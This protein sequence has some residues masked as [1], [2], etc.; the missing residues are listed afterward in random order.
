MIF[1]FKFKIT[2]ISSK[3][4]IWCTEIIIFLVIAKEKRKRK[5]TQKTEQYV[6]IVKYLNPSHSDPGR[7]EKINLNFYFLTSLKLFEAPQRSVKKHTFI[8]ILIQLPKMPR[9][10]RVNGVNNASLFL[11]FKFRVRFKSCIQI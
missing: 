1:P 6:T 11:Y 9:A 8:F 4:V 2:S 10:G 7:R 3:S 5:K